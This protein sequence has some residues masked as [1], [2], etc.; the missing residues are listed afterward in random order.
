MTN[1]IEKRIRAMRST[2]SIVRKV[3]DVGRKDDDGPP[4]P[5]LLGHRGAARDCIVGSAHVQREGALHAGG[6]QFDHRDCCA[7]TGEFGLRLFVEREIARIANDQNGSGRLRS[8]GVLGD[9]FFRCGL[10]LRCSTL[11]VERVENFDRDSLFAT[12]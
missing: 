7:A 12:R 4:V 5:V 3:S 6:L 10:Q 9:K 8:L 11:E 1:M 2:A